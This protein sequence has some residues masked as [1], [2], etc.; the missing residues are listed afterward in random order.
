MWMH[1]GGEGLIAPGLN[2]DKASLR[3][4]PINAGQIL[5]PKI[6]VLS[7]LASNQDF[8]VST[9]VWIRKKSPAIR[10]YNILTSPRNI[11]SHYPTIPDISP[12]LVLIPRYPARAHGRTSRDLPSIHPALR[13]PESLSMCTRTNTTPAAS[14]RRK[15]AHTTALRI[16]S[17]LREMKAYGLRDWMGHRARVYIYV[18]QCIHRCYAPSHNTSRCM[19]RSH[20]SHVCPCCLIWSS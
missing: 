5:A 6:L 2:A 9:A 15:L 18:R 7:S 11:P 10:T 16:R 4:N 3:G 20:S 1:T 19:T 17:A 13:H 12:N 14:P 8:V